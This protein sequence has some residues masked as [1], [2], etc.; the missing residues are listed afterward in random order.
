M[1]DGGVWDVG[2]IGDDDGCFIVEFWEGVVE[3]C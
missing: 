2:W 3:V 1:W